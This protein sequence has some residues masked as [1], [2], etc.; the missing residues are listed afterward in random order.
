MPR[1]RDF[2]QRPS[3]TSQGKVNF[4]NLVLVVNLK[5][6]IH[7]PTFTNVLSD[8]FVLITLIQAILDSAG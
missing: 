4:C 8:L 3:A 7:V 1:S 2:L 6:V 5:R